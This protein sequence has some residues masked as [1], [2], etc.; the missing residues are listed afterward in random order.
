MAGTRRVPIARQVVQSSVTPRASELFT[1]L[2][3]VGRSR[4]RAVGCTITEHGL[5]TADCLA[6]QRWSDLHAAL[7][8][9][10]RLRPWQW[11]CLGR[12]PYPPNSS[13]ADAWRPSSEQQALWEAL[14]AARRAPALS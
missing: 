4:K 14:D 2:E 1:E 9:E 8:T 5:C 7:H 13:E 12:N 6:C 3:R 10:L 11:P